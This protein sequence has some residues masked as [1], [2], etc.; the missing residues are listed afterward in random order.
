MDLE[1]I[2]ALERL[3]E[4]KRQGFL[5]DAEVEAEK[6]RILSSEVPVADESGHASNERPQLLHPTAEP[7]SEKA[8]GA[9][10]ASEGA[11]PVT[12]SDRQSH[13]SKQRGLL[14]GVVFALVAVVVIVIASGNGGD[15]DSSAS[16]QLNTRS[17]Q[18]TDQ[19]LAADAADRMAAWMINVGDQAGMIN[20]AIVSGDLGSRA[21][22]CRSAKTNED[23]RYVRTGY[24]EA[25]FVADA[26]TLVAYGVDASIIPAAQE[27]FE[28]WRLAIAYCTTA[29]WS[30]LTEV[31]EQGSE[32]IAAI[33]SAVQRFNG[34]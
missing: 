17:E 1:R 12:V 32:A 22:A 2:E 27:A 26:E 15:S 11:P 13:P 25:T 9:N 6:N 28:A 18:T 29:N 4:L 20:A 14:L 34:T 10:S 23:S 5:T 31:V 16:N 33:A 19:H 21:N 8:R 30:K 7:E 3:A 24:G